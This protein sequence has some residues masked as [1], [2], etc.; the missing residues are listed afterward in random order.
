MAVAVCAAI[1]GWVPGRALGCALRG[2]GYTVVA[3]LMF[4]P[5]CVPAY[6]LFYAWWQAWPPDSALYRWAV[7]TDN[8]G[9]VKGATVLIGMTCWSWPQF[10]MQSH[11]G[12]MPIRFPKDAVFGW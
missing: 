2:R 4:A 3:A 9:L 8:L 1:L 6:V 11:R 5:I 7:E 12:Q 10:I